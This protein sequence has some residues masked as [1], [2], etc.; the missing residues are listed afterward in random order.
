M[1]IRGRANERSGQQKTPTAGFGG[2]VA[3]LQ[4]GLFFQQTGDIQG[5]AVFGFFPSDAAG[6]EGRPT[7]IT[8]GLLQRLLELGFLLLL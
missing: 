1:E 6:G 5:H 2:R 4:V 3:H 8:H 7:G